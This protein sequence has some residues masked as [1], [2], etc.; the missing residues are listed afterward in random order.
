M[1]LSLQIW[2]PIH[3][4]LKA[5]RFLQALVECEGES[6]DLSGDMGVVGR[7]V[8]PDSSSCNEEMYLDLKGI[9]CSDLLCAFF[10]WT[11]R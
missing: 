10:D 3:D 9:F 1:H 7:V 5:L 4:Q 8:I 11:R 6:I 2:T